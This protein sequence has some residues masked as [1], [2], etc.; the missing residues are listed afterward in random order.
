MRIPTQAGHSEVNP[1]TSPS[2]LGIGGRHPSEAWRGDSPAV[3]LPEALAT[4]VLLDL[5][6]R[7]PSI[8]MG[9]G[10]MPAERVTM[11]KI[12][13]I[14]R[15]K[16]GCELSNR[17]VGQLWGDAQHGGGNALSGQGGGSI[18]AI[19]GGPGRSAAGNPAVSCR[20]VAD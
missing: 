11:R 13:D 10:P 20:A 9:E 12:K 14:L 16:W 19:P 6:H 7:V 5:E 8:F 1:A 18:L 3:H 2:P 15:L 17:Q 4:Q